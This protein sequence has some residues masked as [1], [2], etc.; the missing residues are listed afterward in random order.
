MKNFVNRF[1][2]FAVNH[3]P[4]IY[5]YWYEREDK[6]T[7]KSDELTIRKITQRLVT[8]EEIKSLV[9][10]QPDVIIAT[11]SFAAAMLSDLKHKHLLKAICVGIITDFTVHPY[12]EEA[13]GLDYYVVPGQGRRLSWRER[14]SMFSA[15]SP[16]E[17]DFENH[18][19]RVCPRKKPDRSSDMIHRRRESS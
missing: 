1:Y 14:I 19:L 4:A 8:S 3:T 15:C 13:Y 5:K 16:S 7:D 2:N 17:F 18:F 6:K 10:Q 11:Q 12:W 9:D